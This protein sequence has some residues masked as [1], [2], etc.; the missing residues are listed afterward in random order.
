MSFFGYDAKKSDGEDPVMLELGRIWSTPLLPS[1]PGPLWPAL[2]G[3][4]RVL[5][6]GQIE[7]NCNYAKLNC[8]KLTLLTFICM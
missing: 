4:D 3:P 7:L 8:L 1:L 6:M 5:S 2:V